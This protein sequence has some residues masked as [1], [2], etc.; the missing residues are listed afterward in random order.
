[1]NALN[2]MQ[3]DGPGFIKAPATCLRCGVVFHSPTTGVLLDRCTCGGTLKTDIPAVG[4][5]KIALRVSNMEVVNELR[6]RLLTNPAFGAGKTSSE[7]LLWMTEELLRDG[8][9]GMPMDKSG[10][11]IGF[12][13]GVM[14]ANGVLDVDAERERTRPIYKRAYF[15]DEV[16]P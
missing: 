15:Q 2:E 9:W 3:P 13:Q 8:L 16:K 10:R 14:A 6:N 11:W 7:H 5:H 4:V 1:M 12:I